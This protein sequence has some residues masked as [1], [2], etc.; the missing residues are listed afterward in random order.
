KATP[1]DSNLRKLVEWLG[2]DEGQRAVKAAGYIPLRPVGEMSETVIALYTAVGTGPEKPADYTPSLVWGKP[3][4]GDNYGPSLMQQNPK[5]YEALGIDGLANEELEKEINDFLFK[6]KEEFLK[7]PGVTRISMQDECINGYLA[8]S[9]ASRTEDHQYIGLRTRIYDLVTGKQIPFSDLFFKGEDFISNLN[10]VLSRESKR[11]SWDTD[12]NGNSIFVDYYPIK[13]EFAGIPAGHDTFMLSQVLFGKD[14]LYFSEYTSL[15]ITDVYEKSMLSV[16]RDLTG[17]FDDN[18]RVE[19]QLVQENAFATNNRLLLS[20]SNGQLLDESFYDPAISK[21]INDQLREIYKNEFTDEYFSAYY[22]D[23]FTGAEGCEM[24]L[25]LLGDRWL[26]SRGGLFCP[27]AKETYLPSLYGAFYLFDLTTGEQVS[28]D[29]LLKEGWEEAATWYLA[30]EE[31]YLASDLSI[32]DPT[33][34]GV[35]T[36]SQLD[37]TDWRFADFYA[38]DGVVKVVFEQTQPEL[39]CLWAEIPLDY[40]G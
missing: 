16:P 35:V 24:N 14:N 31:A 15:S 2:T 23:E 12:L 9:V 36:V 29:V 18:V 17:I 30:D 5:T 37:T 13:R 6:T 20:S 32:C 19:W 27:F 22:G 39:G 33:V 34:E 3:I 28:Y 11:Q 7:V 4:Y 26:V 25:S 40:L 38:E 1:A 10:A 8:V 21:K